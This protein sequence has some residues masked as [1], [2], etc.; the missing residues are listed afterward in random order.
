MDREHVIAYLLHRLPATARLDVAERCVIDPVVHEELL[1]A[2]AELLDAYV[3]DEMSHEDRRAVET[4]LLGSPEQRRKLAFAGALHSTLGVP[5]VGRDWSRVVVALAAGIALVTTT[6][7]GWLLRQN[8]MLQ[9]QLVSARPATALPAGE[10]A[11]AI[12]PAGTRSAG[13][14]PRIVLRSAT[15]IVRF[16]LELEPGDEAIVYS[17]EL[18]AAG[19][20]IWREGPVRP[21]RRD[22][23]TVASVWVPAH[24]L[25]ARRYEIRLSAPANTTLYYNVEVTAP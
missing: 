8:A 23:L 14:I 13:D 11:A 15:E 10:V 3:R 1:A 22:T 5:P 6:G 4:H 12:I 9:T 16:D 24:L 21:T 18:L 20:V 19:E 17:L 25:S 2:E 7:A